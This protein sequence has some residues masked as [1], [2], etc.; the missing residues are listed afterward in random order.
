MLACH[1]ATERDREKIEPEPRMMQS[2]GGHQEVPKEDAAVSP[3]GGLRKWRSDRNLASGRHQKPKGRI[4]ASCES[5]RRLTIA[6]RKMTRHATVAWRRNNTVRKIGTEKN[7]GL[8]KK[9]TASG[10][11]KCPEC[12]S[13]TRDRGLRQQL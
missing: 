2:V 12:N 4:K 10:M 9:L 8:R 7:C 6:S 1:E 5:R 13:G 3:G 11:R